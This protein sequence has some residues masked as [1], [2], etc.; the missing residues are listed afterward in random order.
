[1]ITL[2]IC[3][4]KYKSWRYSFCTIVQLLATS[5]PLGRNIFLSTLFWNTLSL[6]SPLQ[7]DRTKF[8]T[9]TK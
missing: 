8:N 5:S 4:T 6:C 3:R 2:T 7:C 1:M 9:H